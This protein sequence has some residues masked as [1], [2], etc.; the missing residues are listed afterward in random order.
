M[1]RAAATGTNEATL[2]ILAGGRSSRMGS[3]KAELPVEGQTLLEWMVRGL[4]PAFAETLVCGA[5]A[6]PGAR[7]VADRH[8]L[9]G[10]LAG[11][12]SGLT[13]M[14]TSY[15][16]VLA[17]DIPGATPR[18]AALLLDRVL[19]HDAAVPLIG[20]RAQPVCAAYRKGVAPAISSY[21]DAGG[22]RLSGLI[23][24][25]KIAYVDEDELTSAGIAGQELADL[26]VPA[27]YDAFIRRHRAPA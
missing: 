18:L 1:K 4:A 10:P 9:A 15:A 27:D 23:E 26:D 8:P 24:Q 6:P 11:I 22:R 2:V 21:L 19:G 16:F 3:P 17:C 12:E 13:A 25:L 20:L 14:R 5:S 7:G